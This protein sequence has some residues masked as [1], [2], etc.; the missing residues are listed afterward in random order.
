MA[1]IWITLAVGAAIIGLIRG[2]KTARKMAELN[3]EI[4]ENEYKKHK[5]G[6]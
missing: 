1:E 6:N 3:T 5:N 4:Y 2:L